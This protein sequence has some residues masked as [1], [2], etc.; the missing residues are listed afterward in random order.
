MYKSVGGTKEEIYPYLPVKSYI[1]KVIPVVEKFYDR[2][3]YSSKVTL[4]RESHP[5]LDESTILISKAYGLIS[6]KFLLHRKSH[7]NNCMRF[8]DRL[9]LRNPVTHRL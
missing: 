8:S 2:H 4:T 1:G 7:Q 3:N 9:H 6:P 5:E